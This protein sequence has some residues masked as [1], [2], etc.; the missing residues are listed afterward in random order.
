MKTSAIIQNAIE[1][2]AAEF[3]IVPGKIININ[4]LF[5]TEIKAQGYTHIVLG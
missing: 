2:K 1:A 4:D 3:G 5:N